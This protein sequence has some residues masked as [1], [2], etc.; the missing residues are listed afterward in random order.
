MT[1]A[2][3]DR[4]F[5]LGAVGFPYLAVLAHAL[6]HLRVGIDN[7]PAQTALILLVI[8]ALPIA[9]IVLVHRGCTAAAAGV[10]LVVGISSFLFGYWYHFLHVSNDF[11]ANA[12]E[13]Y[14]KFFFHSALMIEIVDFSAAFFAASCLV[15][16][17][18][19]TA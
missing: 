6:A 11:Y 16:N 2:K 9:A 13:P 18:E 10:V 3:S 8:M 14:A 1:A 17:L 12:G 7:T 15:R 5:L 4:C 19:Q